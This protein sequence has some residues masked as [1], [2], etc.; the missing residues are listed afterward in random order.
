MEELGHFLKENSFTILVLFTFLI[1][2]KYIHGRK[3]NLQLA[4]QISAKLEKVF[5]PIDKEYTWVGGLT[6]FKA[7]FKTKDDLEVKATLVMKP[8]QSLIYLPISML[9]FGGDKLFVIFKNRKFAQ[10]EGH[11]IES[12]QKKIPKAWLPNPSEFEYIEGMEKN[13][14][15][16]NLLAKDEATM[17]RLRSLLDRFTC[18]GI[19][20]IALIPENETAYFAVDPTGPGIDD[21]LACALD[22]ASTPD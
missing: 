9:I 4:K 15:R 10:T 2:A 16:Y 6:G 20:H 14:K 3:K 13:E 11:I 8:R 21:F 5:N 19:Y 18:R 17:K 12:G 1:L 7:T 22:Y